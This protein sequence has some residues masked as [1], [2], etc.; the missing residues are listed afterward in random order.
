MA[1]ATTENGSKVRPLHGTDPSEIELG[2]DPGVRVAGG[3]AQGQPGPGLVEGLCTAR[4]EIE[5]V[6][7]SGY[8]DHLKHAYS[9]YDDVMAAVAEPLAEAGVWAFESVVKTERW[10]EGTNDRGIP[11]YRVG[12]VLEVVWTDGESELRT[13]WTGETLDTGDKQHYQLLSQITKYAYAKTLKL[14]TGDTDVDA[15]ASGSSGSGGRARKATDNQLEFVEDLQAR[16][17]AAGADPD[18]WPEMQ[19]TAKG[20]DAASKQIDALIAIEEAYKRASG[21]EARQLAAA[22][23]ED[24]RNGGGDS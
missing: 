12:M 11:R 4:Q 6:E 23:V 1:S 10:P 15:H 17:E 13:Y 16:C 21:E 24:A 3:Q 14:Q 5:D 22:G 7:R 20:F 19:R 8:N 9:T 2:P 18:D